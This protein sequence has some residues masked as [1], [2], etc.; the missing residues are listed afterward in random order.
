MPQPKG[1]ASNI[2]QLSPRWG[3]KL[4][5]QVMLRK[6]FGV[7]RAPSLWPP[8]LT[9]QSDPTDFAAQSGCL[10][11]KFRCPSL[12]PKKAVQTQEFATS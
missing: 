3:Y 7:R 1:P 9:G 6:V 8:Q 11:A 5:S 10:L 12:P 2:V 4:A